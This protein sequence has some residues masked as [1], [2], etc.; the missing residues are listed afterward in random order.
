MP[1]SIPFRPAASL[2]LL[3]L[4]ASL[5]A[6]DRRPPLAPAFAS[7]EALA[8]AV[9]DRYRAGDEAG[10][11]ALALT[12]QEFR[13][14]VWPELPA[15]RPSATCRSRK[16]GVTCIRRATSG[17]RCCWRGIAAAAIG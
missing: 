4:M 11:R 8:E 5:A 12:E 13:Q 3:V 6:C 7:A 9:L 14:H 10:L 15:A 17:S 2:A 1:P 16:S